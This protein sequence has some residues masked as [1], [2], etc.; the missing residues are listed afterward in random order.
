MTDEK[1]VPSISQLPKR[2]AMEFGD[3]PFIL[4]PRTVSF[5]EFDAESD[6]FAAG[7]AELGVKKG[8]R[9]ALYMWNRPEFLTAFFGILKVGGVAVPID[10]AFREREFRELL[11]DSE[12][13]VVVTGDVEMQIVEKTRGGLPSVKHVISLD[14]GNGTIKFSEVLKQSPPPE[15][16]I[17]PATD[18]ALIMYAARERGY[19]GSMLTHLNMMAVLVRI[20]KP[21][22]EFIKEG[23]TTL[24]F[25]PMHSIFTLNDLCACLL[26]G[27]S[28]VLEKGFDVEE[29]LSHVEQFWV[30]RVMMPMANI[31]L[32]TDLPNVTA[33][34]DLSSLRFV[35]NV[36]EAL[37]RDVAVEFQEMT[38]VPIINT[39]GL[40]EGSGFVNV[41]PVSKT[42]LGLVGP[43]AWGVEEKIVGERGEELG[44]GEVGELLVRGPQVMK[45]YWKKPE[46]TERVLSGGWLHT[47]D[48]AVKDEE[49]NIEIVGKKKRI[50]K[51]R[52]YGI[53][54]VELEC[55]LKE[56]PA[57]MD[58]V[59]AGK[60]GLVGGEIPK[61]FIVLKPESRAG[62]G[63]LMRW[64][65]ERLAPYKRVREVEF[66][67]FIPW[68]RIDEFIK[69][70]MSRRRR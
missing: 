64:V 21:E 68:D 29:F 36:E 69:R 22:L 27:N 63:E 62:Q 49:G 66:V 53:C 34:Y 10:P 42:K 56:H 8:D 46:E 24:I 3:K 32:L 61:A 58:C 5:K 65:E 60:P 57:V 17:T 43:P 33:R 38:K 13:S 70:M 41:P 28:L 40:A 11:T 6:K 9:V 16:E 67:P 15:V 51:F 54:P 52:G 31:T 50:I 47:G 44:S 4:H 39:Y 2:S 1:T 45:G 48:L 55:V 35:C 59:V 30:S 26:A 18:L 25:H 20:S 12:A 37:I 14:G 23:E 19:M 7:L